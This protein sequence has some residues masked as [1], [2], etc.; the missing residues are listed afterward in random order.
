MAQDIE[1]VRDMGDRAHD[2]EKQY[3]RGDRDQHDDPGHH[4]DVLATTD[5]IALDS[6]VAKGGGHP[7]RD[8]VA[9]ASL[10]RP[11]GFVLPGAGGG[12]AT[13]AAVHRE[14]LLCFP[15]DL[16]ELPDGRG[17]Q[18][19]T[20]AV[21]FEDGTHA[22]ALQP[23][24]GTTAAD[25]TEI[26][27]FGLGQDRLRWTFRAPGRGGT[28]RPDGR[29][30][31]TVVRVPATAEEVS[32]RLSL[33]TV[34]V[35]P[36]LG[37]AFVRRE[38]ASPQDMRFRLRLADA[39]PSAAPLAHPEALPGSWALA[40]YEDGATPA[41]DGGAGR[42][43]HGDAGAG[44]VQ[45][46]EL[47]PGLRRLCLAVDIEK[48]SAR[49]NA[50]MV[51]LQRV[52]LRTLRAACAAA[53][54]DWQRCGRQ[55]QGDGYLLVLEPGIDEVRVVPRLLDGLAAGLATANAA[56]AA[57][58]APGTESD[59]GPTVPRE[60]RMRASLHQG[61]VHEADSGYAGS[62][63]VALF[64]VLD[65]GPVRRRLA[66]NPSSH[67]AVAFSDTLYK[68]LV[69]TGYEGLSGN[70]FERAEIHVESKGYTG[71]AWIQVRP[72][73]RGRVGAP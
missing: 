63:V 27:A 14:M 32:G 49:D 43:S 34:T 53:G 7:V 24:P 13:E 42:E 31:Q 4:D 65:S 68:D 28:L 6:V 52:L 73:G 51:R 48:Y 35:Q 38:A 50:D 26:V 58:R 33:A 37:G 1:G 61:I 10:G 56:A 15:F 18:Q 64:R 69:A 25:G 57:Q 5:L 55:A 66:D 54:V 72:A 17:Y 8:R 30:A 44:S 21:R 62:T 39:W 71:V 41:G 67:L 3:D 60:V 19:V 29:W 20:L 9:R 36:V 40:G 11:L 70:G 22:L 16:E 23:A 2:T 45:G 12:G 46:E 59:R 47:P